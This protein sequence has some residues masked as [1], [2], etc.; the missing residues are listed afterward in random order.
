MTL[1]SSLN[2][3]HI[4]IALFFLSVVGLSDVIADQ[5]NAPNTVEV[6]GATIEYVEQG[7][8]P[9]LILAHGALSDY[10]RWVKVHMPLLAENFRVVS[11]SMRYHGSIPWDKS[12]PQ[13]TVDLYADDLAGL[14]QSFDAGPAHLV[15]WSM[16]SEVAH[17]T[18]LKYPD[19]VRSAYLFEGVAEIEKSEEDAQEEKELESEMFDAIVAA[20]RDGDRME[21][22]RTL[23]DNVGGKV[24]IFDGLPESSQTF[25]STQS[26]VLA[27]YLERDE[28]TTYKCD[29]VKNSSVPT[30]L[31]MG[32]ASVE[33]FQTVLLEHNL[34]CFGEDRITQIKD[35]GHLWPGGGAEDFVNS[36]T[37]FALKN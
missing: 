27:K 7:S 9:L 8:G 28:S 31:V 29:Q 18:A 3:H 32:T 30:T 15:G 19:L 6:N 11:Y 37:E 16:G 36:V 2:I 25:L 26:D 35:A 23:I 12:W 14:I 5:E 10:R 24:G 22:V 17:S 33:Y 21:A 34:P 20:H 4:A 13:L 1:I